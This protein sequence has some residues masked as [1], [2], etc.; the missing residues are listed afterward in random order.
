MD[1]IETDPLR[2]T[3]IDDNGAVGRSSHE[4]KLVVLVPVK[5]EHL[6]ALWS[7]DR[8]DGP[9]TV[10]V[11]DLHGAIPRTR[12]DE[13]VILRVPHCIVHGTS[14]LGEGAY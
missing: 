1:P 6:S 11:P 14:V 13:R 12:S 2:V 9:L 4:F 8:R 7:S 3:H 5:S 10:E